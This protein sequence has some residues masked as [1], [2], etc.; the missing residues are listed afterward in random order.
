MTPGCMAFSQ[1]FSWIITGFL[2]SLITS[3]FLRKKEEQG[4]SAA[5]REIDDEE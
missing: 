1:I 4:F 5:M 3:I 2:I